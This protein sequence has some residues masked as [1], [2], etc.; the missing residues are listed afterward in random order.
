MLYFLVTMNFDIF[1]FN[2]TSLILCVVVIEYSLS[3]SSLLAITIL[4]FD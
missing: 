2:E 4:D 1:T 3:D